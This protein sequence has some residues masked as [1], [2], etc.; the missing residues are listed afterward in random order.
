MELELELGSICLVILSII[1]GLVG[2]RWILKSV[3]W[4]VYEMKL[5]EKQYYLPPGDL[6][7]PYIGNMWSFLKAFKSKDPDSFMSSF[8]SRYGKTGIY[9][10]FMFGNPSIIVTMPETC[11]KVLT[12]DEAFK[13]GWPV[14]TVELIGKKSFIGI[15]YEDHKRLRRLTAAPVNGYEA[16]S[17]YI[18]FIEENVVAS[19][20]RW[21]NYG[22]PIEFL[23]ET[24]RLTFR[25]IIY[26][27][28]SAVD[29]EVMEALEREYTSLNY[30][31]RA[32]AINIP[33]FAYH[34]ALKARKNL[35][36]VFQSIV[37][38]R[39]RLRKDNVPLKTKDMMDCLLDAQDENGKK[40]TDEEIIDVLLMYLNAGHESSGHTMMW[41]VNFLQENPDVLQKAKAEQEQ[42]VKKR[43]PTQKGMTLKEYREMEY[44]SKVIDE[45]LRVVTFSL[46]VF[47]E[48]KT[49]VAIS[50]YTIPKGWKVLVWFRSVH[51]DPEIYPN[52][53][54]FNPSRWDD[55]V[56]KA[57]SFLP[58]GAGSRL[59]PGNDLAKLEIGVFLHHFLLK[60][61]LERLNPKSP[62]QHLP[63]PRPQDNYLARI[64][65]CSSS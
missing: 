61:R 10:A 8:V 45:T 57:G 56:P 24:R 19:L 15:S 63:H 38:E 4:W 30:G 1:G 18:P 34:R 6:G 13:P 25:I 50:G 39:R 21:S 9:R 14:S 23:T 5:G 60:Y 29:N 17:M 43:P 35:V 3:N 52:P 12:D 51:F 33:G 64:S 40:L 32:M 37:T 54:E 58:F 42:I 41:A 47:R 62:M 59:C 20:D 2:V 27:F 65:K 55:Y 28:L 11:K 46:M 36:A 7:W 31:V 53:R 26:I 48:A 49:D 44:L 16:L 22:K